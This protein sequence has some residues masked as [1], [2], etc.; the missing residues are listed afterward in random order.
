MATKNETQLDY[1]M[2]VVLRNYCRASEENDLLYEEMVDL[3]ECLLTLY[4]EN[5]DLRF[6][7]REAGIEVPPSNFVSAEELAELEGLEVTGR[8]VA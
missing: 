6:K 5:A 7:L 2:D 8:T 3:K 4:Q 1:F